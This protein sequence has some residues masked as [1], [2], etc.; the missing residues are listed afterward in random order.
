MDIDQQFF[1]IVEQL[2]PMGDI[3][4][5]SFEAHPAVDSRRCG[6][7]SEEDACC[8]TTTQQPTFLTSFPGLVD[9]ELAAA[10]RVAARPGPADQQ[11]TPYPK[12]DA[13]SRVWWMWDHEQ[14]AWVRRD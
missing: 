4:L 1:S 13:T 11:P 7:G 8:S 6:C 12:W 9:K 5:S 3:K 2:G 14:G 10:E